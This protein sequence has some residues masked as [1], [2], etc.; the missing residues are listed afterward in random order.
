MTISI[1]TPL[2]LQTQQDVQILFVR[3]FLYFLKKIALLSQMI[4][5]FVNTVLFKLILLMR[6]AIVGHL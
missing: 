2:L 4:R 3:L 5:R 6:Q 1:T